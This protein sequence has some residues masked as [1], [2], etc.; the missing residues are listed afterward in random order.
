MIEIKIS[1][2]QLLDCLKKLSKSFG[3]RNA[4]PILNDYKFEID[5]NRLTV[6]VSDYET[7]TKES[8][9][10]PDG[11][12]K[13]MEDSRK[14][15]CINRWKLVPGL[16][17]LDEQE[18]TMQVMDYQVRI[19]HNLGG[20]SIPIE[21]AGEFP[22]FKRELGESGVTYLKLESPGLRH[23]LDI[24]RLQRANDELRPVMNGILFDCKE[25]GLSLV[26]SDGHKLVRIRK[27]NLGGYEQEFIMPGRVANILGYILPKTGMVDFRFS[28]KDEYRS[29]GHINMELD[30]DQ[31]HTMEVFFAGIDGRYPNYNSVIST[32]NSS[33]IS[34]NRR[35]LI[36]S[37]ERAKV[38]ANEYNL[39]AKLHIGNEK[40]GIETVNVDYQLQSDESIPCEIHENIGLP[41]DIG[42][43][44]THMLNLIRHINTENI[45]IKLQDPSR[46]III[47][48]EPQP[49]VEDLTLLIMPMLLNDIY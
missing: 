28:K 4:L 39:M 23:W 30:K 34:V 40:I 38:F 25:D 33:S 13:V 3:V 2:K 5:G 17:T 19:V 48:P 11:A 37:L 42:V 21:D 41:M 31:N 8:F 24:L 32:Y 10:L 45:L 49:D 26:A 1:K 22:A 9:A 27:S 12:I 43:K 46:A 18:I 44:T 20:F 29:V 35:Q 6:V 47:E 14:A 7:L 36:N 16:R 15:W